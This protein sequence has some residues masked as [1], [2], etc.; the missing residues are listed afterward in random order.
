M[1]GVSERSQDGSFTQHLWLNVVEN[2]IVSHFMI[3]MLHFTMVGDDKYVFT[4]PSINLQLQH[5]APAV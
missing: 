2:S 4:F 3:K 5:P 1:V